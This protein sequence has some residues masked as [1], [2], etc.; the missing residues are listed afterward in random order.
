[1]AETSFVDGKPQ[2]KSSVSQTLW[3]HLLQRNVPSVLREASASSNSTIP[4]A[5]VD[6]AGSSTRM[7]LYD[8]QATLEK[9]SGHVEKLTARV[10]DTKREVSTAHKVFEFGHEKLLEQNVALSEY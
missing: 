2:L 6:K 1:M 8:T 4:L 3:G 9:F 5:P 7:L 10:E